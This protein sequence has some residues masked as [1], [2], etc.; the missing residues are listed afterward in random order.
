MYT[1]LPPSTIS[2]APPAFSP[3][4]EAPLS[5]EL[6]LSPTPT[7]EPPKRTLST[8][9]SSSPVQSRSD[10]LENG[11]QPEPA[12]EQPAVLPPHL[13]NLGTLPP[14]TTLISVDEGASS[15]NL[16]ARAQLGLRERRT[17]RN[18]TRD[19]VVKDKGGMSE[20]LMSTSRVHDELTEQLAM[21]R[22]PF[23]SP[24]LI[25][26]FSFLQGK[27][28]LT[29]HVSLAI[30]V[31]P[32]AQMSTQLRKN[33]T[34]FASSLEAEKPLLEQSSALL[35]SNLTKLVGSKGRLEGIKGKGR[36]N[37]WL[38]LGAVGT[39]CL[40]WVWMYFLIRFT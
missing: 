22:F 17:L 37:T 36:G 19:V 28:L 20:G 40:V 24:L 16:S 5:P 12:L 14:P 27:E 34:H 11:I 6:A 1:V 21:V 25:R 31:V 32:S 30:S 4:D 7:S 38:V 18:E 26:G 3:S 33:A 10:L 9:L 2:L 23:L 8:S 29:V 39:V 15:S 35:E 13:S